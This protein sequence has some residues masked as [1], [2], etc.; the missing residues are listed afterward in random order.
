MARFSHPSIIWG[1]APMYILKLLMIAILTSP[2]YAQVAPPAGWTSQN[3]GD[4]IVMKSPA[5][6]GFAQLSL[7]LLP[8]G[9]PIG[10]TKAWFA[11]QTLALAQAAGRPTGSTDVM[12]PQAGILVRAVQVENQNHI[13]IRQVFYGY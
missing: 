11:R 9:R 6:G 3:I 13:K 1:Q 10:E 5:E 4:A 2:L 7:T 12:Q 8:P